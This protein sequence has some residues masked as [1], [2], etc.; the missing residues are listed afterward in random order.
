M[1]L[2]HSE[3]WAATLMPTEGS[4][5]D[6]S[7]IDDDVFDIAEPGAAVLLGEDDAEEPELSRL[8]HHLAGEL[9]RLVDLVD[10]G[11]DL[12]AGELPR[13]LLD[14]ALLFGQGKVHVSSSGAPA[15]GRGDAIAAAPGWQRGEDAP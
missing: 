10:D 7:V 11:I 4:T 1:W 14:G 13:G 15:Q 6:S 3:L 5:F 9:L 2:V 12:A 8:R